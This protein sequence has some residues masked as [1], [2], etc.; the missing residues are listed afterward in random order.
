MQGQQV[1]VQ[2]SEPKNSNQGPGSDKI[3]SLTDKESENLETS[4]PQD[5]DFGKLPTLTANRR[6]GN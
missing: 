1:Q 2:A 5:F 6:M 4:I 3:L